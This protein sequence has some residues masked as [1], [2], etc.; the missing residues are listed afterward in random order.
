MT[1]TDFFE[2]YPFRIELHAH[3]SPASPCS[4]LLPQDVIKIY[5]EQNV[6]AI[7]ITNHFV[8][9]IMPKDKQ[10]AIDTYYQDYLDALKAGKELGVTVYLG[11]ELRFCNDNANDFL[12]F[13]ID[14]QTLLSTFDFLDSTLENFRKNLALPNSVLIQ[15]HPFRNNCTTVLPEL[16]DGFETFN[17][18]PGHNNRNCFAIEFAKGKI[19]TCGSD[20]HHPDLNHE[21]MALLRTKFVPK[22]S[23]ELANLLRSGDYVFEIG[24]DAVVIP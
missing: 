23:F 13:G 15:A 5:K 19:K 11:A 8:S 14:K 9:S 6:D 1:K 10:K 24:K 3:T 12:L 16:V 20:F 22:D 21:A 18:H 2:K 17:S 7:V 4:D